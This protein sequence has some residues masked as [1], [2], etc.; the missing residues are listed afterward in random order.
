MTEI[1]T[2]NTEDTNNMMPVGKGIVVL[3]LN[4]QVQVWRNGGFLF[5]RELDPREITPEFRLFVV[6]LN[7]LYNAQKT[8]LA[9]VFSLS[10]QTLDNWI[11]SYNLYGLPGLINSTKNQGNTNRTKGNKA[12]FHESAKRIEKLNSQDT[13]MSL[14]DSL[15][16]ESQKLEEQEQAYATALEQSSNR[17]AGVFAIFILLV[18]EFKWFKW[19]TAF[20]GPLYKI[21]QIFVLMCAK[22]IGSIEQ[23]K[24]VN[25]KEAGAI[26]GLTRLPSL[27]V[28]WDMFYQTAKNCLSKTMLN[29]YFAWQVSIG[30]IG[31]RFWFTDGH[32]LPYTGKEKMHDIYNTKKRQPEPGCV[33]FVTCD[34]KGKVADFE[35]KEGGSNLRDHIVGLHDKWKNYFSVGGSPVHVFDREGDGCEFFY[36]LI[37]REC[38]FVTWEKNTD[39]TKLANLLESGFPGEILVNNTKY[40]Y[41]ENQKKFTYQDEEGEKHR[42]ALRRFYII[43]TSTQ[44]RTSGLAYNGNTQLTQQDCVYAILNRWGASENTFKHMGN[45]QPISYRPGFNLLS[46][47]NQSITNP[48]V[49]ELKK[50]IKTTEHKYQKKCKEL[51][52]YD[53]NIN[54][55][56]KTRSNDKYTKLKSELEVLKTTID[57]LKREKSVLPERVDISDLRGYKNYKT[58]D[59]EG[60]NMFDFASSLVWNARKTGVEILGQYYPFKNDLVDLFYAIIHCHGK[61][62]INEKEI[63]VI[64]EPLEQRSRRAAQIDF[65]RRLTGLGA[66]TQGG[67]RMIIQVED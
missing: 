50:T 16:P 35:I 5:V 25:L 46:S 10:R 40:L 33:N 22:N 64:L 24:N 49:K 45:R 26:I 8:K 62:R 21:F 13:Q 14:D 30:A 12:K 54:A 17:Y 29:Y 65:C 51:A 52:Q 56:G 28:I 41:L 48:K 3:K 18:S 61:L 47:K 6:E 39:K 11:K 66:K 67:K 60:K 20:Y 19:L 31:R 7:V 1:I 55:S 37:S 36:R 27:P 15:L 53:K 44:K 38:P 43:N 59:N 2:Q 34:V 23:L 58:H 42:F 63:K 57:D 4:N 32:V 9:S